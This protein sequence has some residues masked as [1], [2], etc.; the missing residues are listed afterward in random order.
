MRG[1]VAMEI[2]PSETS[3]FRLF[4]AA[5]SLGCDGS[6]LGQFAL[7]AMG[8]GTVFNCFAAGECCS[9]EVFWAQVDADFAVATNLQVIR[10]VR[11]FADERNAG[12]QPG[13]FQFVRR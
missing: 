13:W 10:Q 6:A 2:S 8:K 5:C 7:P 3:L 12:V 9:W 1:S 4:R 11:A